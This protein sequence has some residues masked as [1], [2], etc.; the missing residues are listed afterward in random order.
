M[1][2]YNIPMGLLI[3]NIIYPWSYWFL[4]LKN[5]CYQEVSGTMLS[6]NAWRVLYDPPGN[7]TVTAPGLNTWNSSIQTW[8]VE[9]TS[10]N[11]GNRILQNLNIVAISAG[12]NISQICNYLYLSSL[13]WKFTIFNFGLSNKWLAC[14][15]L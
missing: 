7:S 15:L 10:T 3:S 9:S 4:I 14:L 13:L 12:N 1:D 5:L 2:E 6:L 11:S 8:L